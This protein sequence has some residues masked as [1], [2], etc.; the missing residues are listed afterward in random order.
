MCFYSLDKK[1][2]PISTQPMGVLFFGAHFLSKVRK[3]ERRRGGMNGVFERASLSVSRAHFCR[4]LQITPS[5]WHGA[6]PNS[7]KQ[8]ELCSLVTSLSLTL[9][10]F[11]F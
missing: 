4:Q 8:R 10:K 5:P 9:S 6:P 11:Q 3:S 7:H 2:S 1:V